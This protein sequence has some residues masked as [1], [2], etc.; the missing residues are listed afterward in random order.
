MCHKHNIIFHPD[1]HY[2]QIGT[3]ETVSILQQQSKN[4]EEVTVAI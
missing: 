4:T 2:V 3:S 1:T